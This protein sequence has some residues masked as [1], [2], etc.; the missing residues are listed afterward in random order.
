MQKFSAE[1]R[2]LGVQM[3]DC[4]MFESLAIGQLDLNFKNAAMANV[5]YVLVFVPKDKDNSLKGALLTS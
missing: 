3:G 2:Q 1:A 5:D 4:V